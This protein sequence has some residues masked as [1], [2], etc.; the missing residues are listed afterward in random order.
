MFPSCD[1]EEVKKN[2]LSIQAF[3]KRLYAD[4]TVYE[5]LLEFLLVYCSDKEKI[6]GE[7]TTYRGAYQFHE[8]LEELNYYASPRI[9]LKRFI[10]FDKSKKENRF[11]IDKK[12]YEAIVN[13]LEKN[14]DGTSEK[15]A[16]VE[17]IQDSFYGFSAVLKSRSWF[18]QSLLPIAPELI[19]TESIGEK[20][21]RGKIRYQDANLNDTE[22]QFQFSRHSFMARGG[23]LYYLHVLQGL[24]K[25]KE[26]RKRL[27]SYLNR[28][29]HA[30]DSLGKLGEFIQNS[31][32]KQ[33]GIVSEE[34]IRTYQ[35]DYIPKGYERR[36][37]Y[38]CE[39][40]VNFLSGSMNELDKMEYLGIG[41]MLQIFRM[42]YEQA[43][44]RTGEEEIPLWLIDVSQG[45]R[46][47][48]TLAEHSLITF[49]ETILAANNVGLCNLEYMRETYEKKKKY[50]DAEL[51]LKL[52]KDAQ[53][54]TTTLVNRLGKE[55]KLIIPMRG[56]KERMTFSEEIVTFLVTALLKPSQK[57]TVD[58][59]YRKLFEHFGMVI[60]NQYAKEYCKVNQITQNYEID[61]KENEQGFLRLLKNCGYLRELS[62][63]TAIVFNPYEGDE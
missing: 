53:K 48:G 23:E 22:K 57:V 35:C 47:I 10:F 56:G 45:N 43:Q 62:D 13:I 36:S 19:F 44:L 55:I 42:M 11:F 17:I 54:H 21:I 29:V 25:R 61:F 16:V 26:L 1:Y 28:L 4:Q 15:R 32:E 51:E 50:N 46:N 31:W 49:K 2:N 12:N 63:A 37:G 6:E 27:E 33:E 9:G 7:K 24:Q 60:G 40:L 14:I 30:V 58:T 59:F 34:Q 5:Y 3:G 38:T 41:I 39:E 20:K 18:A 8:N 52:M